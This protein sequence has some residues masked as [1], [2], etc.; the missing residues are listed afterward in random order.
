MAF[1]IF[2]VPS[3]VAGGVD[4]IVVAPPEI[5]NLPGSGTNIVQVCTLG[6]ALNIVLDVAG[7]NKIV[8][9]EPIVD[10]CDNDTVENLD[11]YIQID[12][13]GEVSVDS[14][15]LP[16][17][18]NKSAIITMRDLEFEEEP[19]IEVDGKLATSQDIGNKTWDQSSKTLTFEA[20][21]FT[22]YKAVA[23]SVVAEDNNSSN[24]QGEPTGFYLS[25]KLKIT[26]L[27]VIFLAVVI[28]G[29]IL[30]KRKLSK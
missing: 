5:F 30:Y 20:K 23:K 27:I 1:I 22:T 29:Y 16:Y 26:L 28:F 7:E 14:D 12:K 11:K 2:A 4:I 25:S 3:L 17:L 9:Q 19:D 6:E 21:H 10:M 24:V 15:S 8:F 13:K 18:K